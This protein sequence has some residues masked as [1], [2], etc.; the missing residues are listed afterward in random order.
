MIGLSGQWRP[1]VWP[2]PNYARPPSLTSIRQQRPRQAPPRSRP[3]RPPNRIFERKELPIRVMNALRE[4]EGGSATVDAIVGFALWYGRNSNGVGEM[5]PAY[6]RALQ[7]I[8]PPKTLRSLRAFKRLIAG[9]PP[10]EP[11]EKPKTIQD[12]ALAKLK[13]GDIRTPSLYFNEEDIPLLRG[14]ELVRTLILSVQ[15]LNIAHID[16][17]V[18]E[19][20]T[21]GGLSA[22]HLAAGM[23]F[24]P[25]RQPLSPGA[26][27]DNPF[28]KLRLFDSFVGL[29]EITSPVDLESPHVVS[30]SWSKGGCKVLSAAQLRE[31]VGRVLPHDRFEIIEGWFADTVAALADDTKFAMIH[32]DGDLYQSTMDALVPCFER[33]FLSEGGVICFDDWNVNRSIP[34]FGE[35]RAWSELVERF[36]IA[37]TYSGEYAAIGAKFI[38]H[39][40]RGM[41]RH[42]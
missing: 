19:F 17:D 3:Y 32:F 2:D 41:R 13:A 16:G 28:R 6:K 40:Y 37:A 38:I 27:G 4:A 30:G 22:R 42:A 20:G 34:T 21:M 24:D 23:V 36:Q 39:S 33:G 5:L 18:A 29:P 25:M 12:I 35:R 14:K 8:V 10:L 1:I 26:S 31:V 11:L 7:Q 15:Y 9:E